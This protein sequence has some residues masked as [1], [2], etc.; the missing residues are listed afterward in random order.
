MNPF[1]SKYPSKMELQERAE[2]D[3]AKKQRLRFQVA[4]KALMETPHG[5]LAL[6]E[7]MTWGDPF[8]FQFV[9]DEGRLQY[10]RG[11]QSQAMR[12]FNECRAAS[13]ELYELMAKEN[14][15]PK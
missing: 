2:D 11:Q 5:R 8:N 9:G 10:M 15:G 12:L 14:G 13:V 7:I 4:V 1:Q 6:W 3:A